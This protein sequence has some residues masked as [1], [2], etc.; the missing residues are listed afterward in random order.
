MTSHC[1]QVTDSPDSSLLQ[2]DQTQLSQAFFIQKILQSLNHL[3]PL[4]TYCSKSLCTFYWGAQ[5]QTQHSSYATLRESA[6]EGSSSS[7]C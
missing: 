5:N 6:G 3:C 4:W 2:A 7:V 1:M